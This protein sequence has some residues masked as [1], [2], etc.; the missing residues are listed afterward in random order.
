ME[1]KLPL[2]EE[3]WRNISKVAMELGYLHIPEE[4]I[5]DVDEINKYPD[6][7]ITIITTGSQGEPMAA[8]SRIASATIE[9]IEIEQG[10]LVIISASPIPGNEKLISKVINE[11]FKKGANVIYEYYRRNSCF[12]ACLSRRIKINSYLS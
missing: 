12:R 5:I 9:S 11:L 8:L 4:I 6:E 10:D 3:V 7:K 2:V 1:E